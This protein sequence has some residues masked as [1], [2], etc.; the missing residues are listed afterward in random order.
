MTNVV[1]VGIGG[2]LG[3]MIR[4][5]VGAALA[6]VAPAAVTPYATM[7]VNLIGCLTIGVL[8][9]LAASGR[10]A[11]N[12]ALRAFVF[13]GVLGGFTTFSSFG[14]DTVT[15]LHGGRTGTAAMNV[16]VQVAVGLGLAAAGYAVA[17]TKS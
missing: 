7:T 16:A 4:H 14:L 1:L 5:A 2:A 11:F 15:L 6:R 17:L 10:M 8:A 3:S 13:V 12:P 9:G